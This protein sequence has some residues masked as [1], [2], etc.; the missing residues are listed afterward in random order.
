MIF[1]LLD[2]LREF[3]WLGIF[4]LVTFFLTILFLPLVIVRLPKDYFVREKPNGFIN[5]QNRRCRV[6]LLLMKNLM[7]LVLILMGFLMLFV[8]GQGVLTILAGLSVMN[9][10]G[11]RKL[12]I[13]LVSKKNVF[14]SLNWIRTKAKRG[15]F[16][17]PEKLIQS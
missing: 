5:R 15:H 12:E 2:L 6:A 17:M 3:W 13:N 7:G 10:P 16:Q 11:K 1:H 9:F 14:K 8:P 4:S